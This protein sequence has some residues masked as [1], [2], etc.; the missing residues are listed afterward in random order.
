MVSLRWAMPRRVLGFPRPVPPPPSTWV[1]GV[2][3]SSCLAPP[4]QKLATM[5]P[6]SGRARCQLSSP[7]LVGLPE[8]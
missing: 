1:Q 3:P 8:F 7:L 6:S 4:T 5:P 2:Q